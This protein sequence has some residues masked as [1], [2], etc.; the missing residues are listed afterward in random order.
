MADAP[1]PASPGV[2]CLAV[3]DSCCELCCVPRVVGLQA[4]IP[5]DP[6]TSAPQS[7][8]ARAQLPV[9]GPQPVTLQPHALYVR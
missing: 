3:Q 4:R 7:P 8:A 2:A 9:H 1:E 6:P 5:A